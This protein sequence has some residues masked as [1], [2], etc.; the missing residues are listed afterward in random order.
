MAAWLPAAAR[1]L[2]GRFVFLNEDAAKE[3]GEEEE[4]QGGAFE[5]PCFGNATAFYLDLGFLGVAMPPAGIFTRLTELCLFL[6]RF[7]F[8]TG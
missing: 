5:L 1:R 8:P 7:F 4:E 6:T 3:G 2:S